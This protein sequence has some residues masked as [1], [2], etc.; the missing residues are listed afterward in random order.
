LR[1]KPALSPSTSSRYDKFR[2]AVQAIGQDP[3]QFA[4]GT[5]D[6]GCGYDKI[7]V[8]LYKRIIKPHI[9]GPFQENLFSRL[10]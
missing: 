6:S 5:T 1:V 2:V 4:M 9:T 7:R 8:S 3:P 10:I